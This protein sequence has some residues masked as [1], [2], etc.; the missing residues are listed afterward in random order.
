M[1]EVT[2]DEV[3]QFLKACILPGDDTLKPTAADKCG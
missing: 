1:W 3:T 2:S